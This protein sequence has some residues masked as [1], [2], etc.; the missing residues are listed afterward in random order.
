MAPGLFDG[1]GLL[2]AKTGVAFGLLVRSGYNTPLTSPPPAS[3]AFAA[4]DEVLLGQA[5]MPDAVFDAFV[6]A[7]DFAVAEWLIAVRDK[8]ASVDDMAALEA[9]VDIDGTL[10]GMARF[11]A[12]MG[13]A[14]LFSSLVGRASV[15]AEAEE[16]GV[17]RNA[18]FGTAFAA[19][20]ELVFKGAPFKRAMDFLRAKVAMPSKIWG[21]LDRSAHDTGFAIA[22]E[23]KR[24]VLEDIRTALLDAIETGTGLKGFRAEFAKLIASGKW[25]GDERLA[26]EPKRFGWRSKIIYWTNLS[27]SHAA[28]RRQQQRE[29]TDVLPFWQYRHG[30]TRTPR[31]PRVRHLRL[32]GLTLPADDPVWDRIYTPNGWLC[33]CAIRAITRTAA[34]RVDPNLREAPTESEIGAAIDHE[35]QHAPGLGRDGQEP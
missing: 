30:A 21:E 31:R 33:S 13:D 34:G 23:T 19:K 24:D 17:G 26:S 4:P 16:D 29:L 32:D 9:L 6:P 20:P 28:G 7:L 22:G 2:P 11:A 10:P 25:S 18:L 14:I 35:W 5:H 1:E 8:L 27:T 15:V 3:P 12:V